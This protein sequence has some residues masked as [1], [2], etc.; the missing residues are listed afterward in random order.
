[1]LRD[2]VPKMKLGVSTPTS[3]NQDLIPNLTAVSGSSRNIISTSSLEFPGSTSEL[4]PL[5][6]PSLTP[7]DS[8]FA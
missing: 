5:I 4:I 7:K 1:M 8:E 2:S 3:A 6:D